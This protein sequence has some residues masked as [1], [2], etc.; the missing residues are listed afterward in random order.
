MRASYVALQVCGLSI[1]AGR[2]TPEVRC[3]RVGL[4]L[5]SP[6]GVLLFGVLFGRRFQ[7][8]WPGL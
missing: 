8:A 4:A 1:I 6:A 3:F 2:L 7:M 5:D